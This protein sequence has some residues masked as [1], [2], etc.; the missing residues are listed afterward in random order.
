MSQ[1]GMSNALARLRM[2]I[3]DP[4]LVRT[5]HGYVPTTRA[6]VIQP[7]LAAAI[8]HLAVQAPQCNAH[9]R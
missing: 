9:H 1:P 3:G 8:R 5:R 6:Q 4:L 7:R 2:L